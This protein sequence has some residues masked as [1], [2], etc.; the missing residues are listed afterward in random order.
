[1]CLPD[2]GHRFLF[3]AALFRHGCG[4]SGSQL[5]NPLLNTASLLGQAILHLLS[6]GRAAHCRLEQVVG[7]RVQ[8]ERPIPL[9]RVVLEGVRCTRRFENAHA[10]AQRVGRCGGGCLSRDGSASS[11][12][13]HRHDACRH[14]LSS[15]LS[16]K[17]SGKFVVV[18]FIVI[19]S[20]HGVQCS[21][22]SLS[23]SD[24][25]SVVWVHPD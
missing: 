18:P 5:I 9:R 7:L 6:R 8:T 19:F 22:L 12:F 2:Q 17:L 14:S 25:G 21:H 4:L 10:L 16:S 11:L 13:C 24:F 3:G 15:F 23:C 20:I 1:M